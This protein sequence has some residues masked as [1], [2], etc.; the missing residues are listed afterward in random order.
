MKH[1]FYVI[2]MLLILSSCVGEDYPSENTPT[3]NFEALWRIMDEHYCFFDYKQQRLGV[4]WNEIHARYA[5]KVNDKMD[6]LQL[7]E[8]LCQMLGELKDGHVNLG[9]A[10]DFGRNWSYYEDYP[11][12]Y[13]A[14]LIEKY[15]GKGNDYQILFTNYNLHCYEGTY[16]KNFP[17]LL[18]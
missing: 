5:A 6:N 9:A 13:N 10:F 17:F 11:K 7:F 2:L 14:E 3:N 16:S 1:W 15:L 12:N 4:D 18:A 8:V